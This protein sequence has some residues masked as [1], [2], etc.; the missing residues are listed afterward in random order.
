MCASFCTPAV[1]AGWGLPE[2]EEQLHW[3]Q[4]ECLACILVIFCSETSP[5]AAFSGEQWVR[6]F[7]LE[8]LL[9]SSSDTTSTFAVSDSARLVHAIDQSVSSH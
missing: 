4:G 7:L 2:H 9:K 5:H 8:R 1:L 3:P 6:A